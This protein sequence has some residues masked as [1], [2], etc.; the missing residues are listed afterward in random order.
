MTE[1]LDIVELIMLPGPNLYTRMGDLLREKWPEILKKQQM[2]EIQQKGSY[3]VVM[4]AKPRF[5]NDKICVSY[6]LRRNVVEPRGI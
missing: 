1:N 5:R 2:Y 4:I 6:A 3:G